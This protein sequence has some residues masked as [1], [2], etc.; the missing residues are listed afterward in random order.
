MKQGKV[1][2]QFVLQPRIYMPGI[3]AVEQSK[4]VSAD[5]K[6]R[7]FALLIFASVQILL[8]VALFG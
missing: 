3:A 1:V 5:A 8:N 4:E 6:D 7:K 2:R